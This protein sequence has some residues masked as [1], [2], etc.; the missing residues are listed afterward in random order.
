[1]EVVKNFK[2]GTRAVSTGVDLREENHLSSVNNVN[3][4]ELIMPAPLSIAVCLN[5]YI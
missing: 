1:M 3:W 4:G 5:K 2:A